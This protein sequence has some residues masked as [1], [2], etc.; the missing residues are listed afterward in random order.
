MG[1]IAL[2]A[3]KEGPLPLTLNQQIGAAIPSGER[4]CS[5]Q[6]YPEGPNPLISGAEI[7]S[8]FNASSD[9]IIWYYEEMLNVLEL[10]RVTQVLIKPLKIL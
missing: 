10:K 4:L 1:E 3:R 2:N 5:I 9:Q 6:I 7:W 8:R